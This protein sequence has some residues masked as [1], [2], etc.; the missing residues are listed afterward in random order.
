[1]IDD[2]DIGLG[3]DLDFQRFLTVFKIDF[4]IGFKRCLSL[5]VLLSWLCAL[6]NN[7]RT[8]NNLLGKK[9]RH[10]PVFHIYTYVQYV[11]CAFDFT[12]VVGV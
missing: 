8:A 7:R 11:L 4:E 3:I 10:S 1:M 5:Y 12:H 2:F 9:F 6:F